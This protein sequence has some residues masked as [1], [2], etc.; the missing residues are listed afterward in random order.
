[1]L[2]TPSD[3]LFNS[4][5]EE[6]RVTSITAGKGYSHDVGSP[7]TVSPGKSL[8]FSVPLS[9]VGPTWLLRIRF[10]FELPPVKSGRQP[11]A[12]VDFTW[13][14]VPSKSRHLWTQLVAH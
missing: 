3:L 7:A 1:M 14:D 12:F 10:E 5:G 13:S 6:A 8:L 4:P 2:V 11:Y 9:H